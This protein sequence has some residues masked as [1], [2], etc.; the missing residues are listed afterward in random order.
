MLHIVA[1]IIVVVAFL[2]ALV[3]HMLVY[4]CRRVPPPSARLSVRLLARSLVCPSRSDG[5]PSSF[6]PRSMAS[7][8]H[9]RARGRSRRI[10]GNGGAVEGR[11]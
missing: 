8:A 6:L 2:L 10:S 5:A 7:S 4:R 9:A 3:A 11:E 1:A